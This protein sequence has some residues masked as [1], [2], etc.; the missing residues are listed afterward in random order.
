MQLQIMFSSY[1]EDSTAHLEF[2][3]RLL[4]LFKSFQHK[5]SNDAYKYGLV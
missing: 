1:G 2:K 4:M 3:D 5:Y